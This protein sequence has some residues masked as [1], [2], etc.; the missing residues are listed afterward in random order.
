MHTV[1]QD[2]NASACPESDDATPFPSAQTR[3]L[4]R[5]PPFFIVPLCHDECLHG[6]VASSCRLE[7]Y[8]PT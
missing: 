8:L 6:R 2:D 1:L 7:K 3:P 5:T 4:T